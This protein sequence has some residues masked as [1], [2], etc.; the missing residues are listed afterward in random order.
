MYMNVDNI[1]A[2]V[3][4][5]FSENSYHSTQINKNEYEKM[6]ELY[7]KNREALFD[8]MLNR[9]IASKIYDLDKSGKIKRIFFE[10]NYIPAPTNKTESK[11]KVY[12]YLQDNSGNA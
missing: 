6:P 2:S 3:S 4:V 7:K 1:I 10:N 5:K 9:I 11:E 12:K 8:F